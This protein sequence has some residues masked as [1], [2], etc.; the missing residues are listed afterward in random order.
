VDEFNIEWGIRQ[1][2][3]RQAEQWETHKPRLYENYLLQWEW[4]ETLKATGPR[5]LSPPKPLRSASATH[6]RTSSRDR[7]DGRQPPT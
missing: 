6:D 5:F 1:G 4:Q 2:F 7:L 3:L